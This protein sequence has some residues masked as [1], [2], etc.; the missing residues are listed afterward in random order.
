MFLSRYS[1]PEAE[2]DPKDDSVLQKSPNS[3]INLTHNTDG[4]DSRRERRDG[5]F[6]AEEDE[7]KEVCFLK[8]F[9]LNT[10]L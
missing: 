2:A 7:E 10:G 6:D 4:E 5:S 9:D 3:G 8:N 1:G